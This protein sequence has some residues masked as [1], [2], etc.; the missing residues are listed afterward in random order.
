QKTNKQLATNVKRLKNP[1]Y[2]QQLLRDKYGY[3]KAG[4]IIYNL[5]ADNN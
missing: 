5:P 4:E 3:S 2:L 1:T